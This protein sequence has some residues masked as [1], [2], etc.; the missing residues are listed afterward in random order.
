MRHTFAERLYRLVLRF[1]PVEFRERFGGDMAAAYRFARRD[2]ES[3]GRAGV[4]GFWLGVFGD[5]FIRGP[6][7]HL[8][9][10]LAD[11]RYAARGLRR[12]PIFTTVAVLTI[13][14][15][16]GANTAIFSAVRAVALRPLGF[17]E[18]NRLVRIWENNERLKI[19]RFAVSVPNY[20]SW[21]EQATVFDELAGWRSVSTTLT[22]G[23]EPQ[24]IGTL[25]ATASVLPLLGIR[26]LLGRNF[27]PEEDRPGGPKVAILFESLW[28]ER[29]GAD[30]ALVGRP[31]R[32]DGVP[33][34][35]VGIAPD[36]DFPSSAKVMVPL[37][38][39][40]THESRGNHMMSVVG[41][42][43]H[44]V[45]LEQAQQEMNA[46]A[47][48]LGQTYAEDQDWGVTLATFYDWMIPR[49]VRTG[50]YTLLAS[51]AVVLLIACSNV[52]N[53]M[54]A[55][56]ALRR[57]E[58]AVRL[59]LGASRF[60][61]VRQ[62]FTE[63]LL[64]SAAGG[65]LG[66]L[67]ASWCAPVLR[68]QLAVALPRADRI[69]IDGP[70]LWFSLGVTL[71]T[72]LL[73]G[74]LPAMLQSGQD[75]VWALKDGGRGAA[76]RQQSRARQLLVIGQVALATILLTAG[77]LLIQSFNRL[78]GVELGFDASRLT[79]AMMGLPESRYQTQTAGLQFYERLL[80][81]LKGTAGVDAAAMTSGAPF[82]G[83]NTGMSIMAVGSNALG[84]GEVQADWRIVSDDYFRALSIPQLRGRSFDTSDGG[85]TEPAR[86][87]S[88][89]RPGTT[90][91]AQ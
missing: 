74:V 81:A 46:V 10:A 65:A 91:L 76:A 52:A 11:V 89:R 50:L 1:Y 79:T 35:I 4:I 14:M 67:V 38:A 73:F 60:R 63:S 69:Q 40:L 45:T 20:V 88:E 62:V 25:E 44:G 48:R 26:P 58:L 42:L 47:H 82:D 7:E 83:G 84:S 59:A 24:R 54:L 12:S 8:H 30:P 61:V 87:D 68:T 78:Q 36:A 21:R 55:R 37:A 27:L 51:V 29:F 18:S 71:A 34:V 72:G 9:A 2:A 66:L 86:P 43:R 90:L 22:T 56:G 13:A 28:R 41:R 77:A 85:D 16:I 15:G 23:G 53:L 3:R 32:L 80:D 31:I 33:H 64:V 39:D 17:A 5:A 19:T 75:V 6:V 49:E 57:R 70:V